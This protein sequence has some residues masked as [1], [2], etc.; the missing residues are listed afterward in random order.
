MGAS[1]LSTSCLPRRAPACSRAVSWAGAKQSYVTNYFRELRQKKHLE[2]MLQ[3]RNDALEA[4]NSLLQVVSSIAQVL[5]TSEEHSFDDAINE[6]LGR[7]AVC[8]CV[9]R[10]YIWQNHTKDDG[11]L[12][13]DQMY[14]WSEGSPPQQGNEYCVD[15]SYDDVIPA[16]R[17]AFEAGHGV[18]SLVCNLSQSEQEQLSPQGII[19]ILVRPIVLTTEMWGFIGFDDCVA[20]R[21]WS[22]AEEA[23]L[24]ACGMLIAASIQKHRVALDLRQAKE[25]AEAATTA[26]GEFLARMSHEIRTPMNA[27]LGLLYLC[28]QTELSPVQQDYIGKAQQSAQNLL[29]IINDILDFSKIEAQRLDIIDGPFVIDTMLAHVRAVVDVKAQEK[30]LELLWDVAPEVPRTLLGDAMRLHQVL[31]NL[32]GNAIKFTETGS[33]KVSISLH[34]ADGE[35]MVRV[36]VIDTGPGLTAVEQGQLFQPFS[37]M[38]GSI[39]RRYGGTGLGLVICK[40]LV[41]LMGGSIG[42]SSEKNVGSIFYFTFPCR[43]AHAAQSS[44]PDKQKI[45]PVSL[46]GRRVLLVEDNEINQLIAEQVLQQAGLHVTIACNGAEAC[47]YVENDCFDVILM[48]V[49]M[50]VMDG[51]EATRRIRAQS[52]TRLYPPI[53]A[54]TANAMDGDRE[55]SLAAGMNDHITK[56]FEPASLIRVLH[57]WIKKL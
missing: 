8:A 25:L 20:E 13:C 22:P 5:L 34:S 16:W 48:D 39:T 10:V 45:L 42:V 14:E 41:E 51:L 57:K 15:I 24:S 40:Q 7:L 50:P 36:A 18:N 9:S 55:R 32:C 53:I 56:P 17:D 26:K 37:Q 12:Y 4:S 29:G 2:A 3:K 11:R 43:E 49:Q 54:M 31:V 33:V 27:I 47:T 28:L 19:S 46:A 30:T 1:F 6:V 23:I 52:Q 44:V 38:D 35:R 21:T